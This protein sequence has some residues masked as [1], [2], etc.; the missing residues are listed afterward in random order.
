M[1]TIPRRKDFGPRSDRNPFSPGCG[2][3]H[4]LSVETI[5][6]R[7]N[8]SPETASSHDCSSENV[9]RKIKKVKINI[10]LPPIGLNNSNTNVYSKEIIK[11]VVK[12]YL[13][14]P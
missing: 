3:Q 8:F 11:T 10:Q 6:R 7:K 5:S 1:E 14:S 13:R 12:T 2:K 4:N 9:K